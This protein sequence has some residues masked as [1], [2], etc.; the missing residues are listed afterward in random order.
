MRWFKHMTASG[1][2]EKLIMLKDEFGM[3]GYGVYWSILE[4]IAA[5]INKDNEQT[6]V[7]FSMKF[8]RKFTDF[9][10]KKWQKYVIFCSE[11][12]LFEGVISGEKIKINCPNI[13]K[14]KDEYSR[15]SGVTPDNAENENAKLSGHTPNS[16]TETDTDTELDINLPNGKSSARADCPHQEII[17]IYREELPCCP[18]VREWNNTRAGYLRSRW[19]EKPE[20]Q[21]LDW[22]RRLFAYVGKSDFLAGRTDGRDGKPPFVA[23]LEWIVKPSNFAKIIE[24]R[25]HR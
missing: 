1:Q 5:Q 4:L 21:D 22:W 16:F 15:K 23:D 9:S 24:G 12:G 19:N 20:R 8:W 10:P 13:L 14:Y 3:A 6:F 11:I 25:Y 17:K 7:E 2:D 18:D